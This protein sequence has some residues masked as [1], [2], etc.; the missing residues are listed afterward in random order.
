MV[1]RKIKSRK[2]LSVS[3]VITNSSTQIFEIGI[4]EELINLINSDP[5]VSRSVV[6][7]YNIKDVLEEIKK[8]YSCIFE[9][10]Y[11]NGLLPGSL[12]QSYGKGNLWL[13][14]NNNGITDKQI[15]LFLWPLLKDA[16]VNKIWYAYEDDCGR[17][18]T[19][20]FLYEHNYYGVRTS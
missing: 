10:I 2:F 8:E 15:L 4:T 6:V 3:G 12:I 16:L 14:L 1:G 17:D 11:S 7:I 18:Y 9:V 20:E 19:A 13:E 5:N